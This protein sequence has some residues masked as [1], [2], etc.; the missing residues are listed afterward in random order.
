MQTKGIFHEELDTCVYHMSVSYAVIEQK[1]RTHDDNLKF[2][3][4]E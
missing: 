4:G 2:M 3:F 1:L